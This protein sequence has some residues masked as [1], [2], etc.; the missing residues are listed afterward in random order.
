MRD[1]VLE[2][3]NVALLGTHWVLRFMVEQLPYNNGL[4]RAAGDARKGARRHGWLPLLGVPRHYI[5]ET[6]E[7]REVVYEGNISYATL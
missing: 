4:S 3:T 2:E 1:G 6:G 7:R 5:P